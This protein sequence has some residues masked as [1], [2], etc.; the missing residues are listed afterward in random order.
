[1]KKSPHQGMT[2]VV[3]RR[4]SMPVTTKSNNICE[5]GMNY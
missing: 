3:G 5:K 2:D 4:G 1:M